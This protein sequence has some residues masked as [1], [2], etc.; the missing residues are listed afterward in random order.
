MTAWHHFAASGVET[1]LWLPPL[2]ALV[3]ALFTSMVGISGAFLLVPFQLSVLGFA[4]PAASAT[5]LV[6]NLVA[7]PG[8]M[9]RYARENR[10]FWPLALVIT[11]GGA[12]GTLAGAW[13]RTHWLAERALFEPFVAA[14]L[15][16]LA[17]RML[18]DWRRGGAA[19]PSAG[20]VRLLEADWREI[21]F[22]HGATTHAFRVLPMLGLSFV[23]GVIGTAYGIGGGSFM[24]PLCLA[25][26]RLP[27]HA[28]AGATLTAT[29]LTSMIALAAY[30]W[31]P[32]PAGVAVRPDWALGLAF[33]V[34]GLAGAY[35]G[36]RMQKRVSQRTL[37][38]FLAVL[39][40]GLAIH[41]AWPG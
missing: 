28:I 12:P 3:I 11:A 40:I 21:R 38:G 20:T 37:K 18:A 39:L 23:V 31:L 17:W 9:L 8:G 32:A 19:A 25:V 41:Y 30:A 27:L 1:W 33:G 13:L 36:A 35:L 14:I 7:I 24:V 4:S 6:F 10:L 29:L 16:Y 22:A 15:A 26:W 2:A 5:N 34:G